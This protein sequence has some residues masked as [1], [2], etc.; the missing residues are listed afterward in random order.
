VARLWAWVLL[1]RGQP[2]PEQ[3]SIEGPAVYV[4]VGMSPYL[5]DPYPRSDEPALS[6]PAQPEQH[7][8]DSLSVAVFSLLNT[9]VPVTEVLFHPLT[10]YRIY[11]SCHRPT[12]ASNI[13][14]LRG[15]ANIQGVPEVPCRQVLA[16][17]FRGT[18]CSGRRLGCVLMF[19]KPIQFSFDDLLKFLV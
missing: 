8:L 1:V 6:Q 2:P 16:A 18:G 3:P 9:L 12:T 19:L 7:I 17:S 14:R 4:L 5:P 15:R 11:A 10:I 13:L